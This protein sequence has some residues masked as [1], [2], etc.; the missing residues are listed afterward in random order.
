[1]LSFIIKAAALIII[2]EDYI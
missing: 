1:M 2:L